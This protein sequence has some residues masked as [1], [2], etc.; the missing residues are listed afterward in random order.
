MAVGASFTGTTVKVNVSASVKLFGP[1]SVAVTV[2]LVAPC[3]FSPGSIVNN[4][5]LIVTATLASED[6]AENVILSPSASDA[7]RTKLFATS[8]KVV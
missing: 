4:E 7:E 3:Q 1:V 2:I 8:S 5:S 6:E